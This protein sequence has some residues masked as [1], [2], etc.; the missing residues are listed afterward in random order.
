MPVAS[1]S[2][3][4]ILP[5][6]LCGTF[7]PADPPRLLS[8]WSTA[9]VLGDVNDD[10]FN[11]IVIGNQGASTVTV[12]ESGVGSGDY[13]T[14]GDPVALGIGD[15]NGDGL[16][17]IITSANTASVLM[18][19]SRGI[20]GPSMDYSTTA[21]SQIIAGD[22]DGSGRA[23]IVVSGLNEVSVLPNVCLP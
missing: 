4:M 13:P 14:N 9:I 16:T 17:D 2:G 12:L 3:S 21:R 15:V 20:F 1:P 8:T 10:G 5:H 19:T 7:I 18:A 22:F 6:P 11:D 23:S